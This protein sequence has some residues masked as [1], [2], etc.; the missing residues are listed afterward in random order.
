MF[1]SR[2]ICASRA[3]WYAATEGPMLRRA[4][5][6]DA[7]RLG[8]EGYRPL[9]GNPLVTC[10][11]P[12]Y[13]R[14]DLLL[15]RALPSMVAQ[16]YRNLEIIVAAHDCTDDTVSRVK[17]FAGFE[18]FKSIIRVIE[19]PRRH[20]YKPTAE[21]H[22]FASEVAPANAALKAARGA[23]IARID[24]DDEW[25]PDH[26]ERLLG[27]AQQYDWEFI[28]SGYERVRD[29]KRE[30]VWSDGET[31]RIGGHQTWLYRSYLRFMRYNPDCWRKSWNRVNDMDLAD[32]FRKA[33]V[34]IGYLKNVTA[35]VYPRPGDTTVGLEAYRRAEGAIEKQ[36]AF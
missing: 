22:W 2:V 16:T 36:Y 10:Y 33:G 29:G 18:G 1:T 13:N 14:A 17:M 6:R 25:A 28:S 24:D 5:R 23:W 32:R 12:T 20:T 7:G 30:V 21:N 34:R 4:R 19:V 26:I 15:K 9:T 27:A 35:Y 3:A 31:P 11:V 8:G